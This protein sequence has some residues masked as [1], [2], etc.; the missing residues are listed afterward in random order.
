MLSQRLVYLGCGGLVG[1]LLARDRNW[2]AARR[3]MWFVLLLAGAGLLVLNAVLF[4]LSMLGAAVDGSPEENALVR[5]TSGLNVLGTAALLIAGD[6]RRLVV[7]WTFTAVGV[8]AF[9]FSIALWELR[10]E[11]IVARWLAQPSFDS[12]VTVRL[13]LATAGLALFSA[14]AASQAGAQKQTAACDL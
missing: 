11:Q 7:C 2:P 3:R 6:A 10:Y 8:A 4:A 13:P 12:L 9:L 5:L 14:F 1:L